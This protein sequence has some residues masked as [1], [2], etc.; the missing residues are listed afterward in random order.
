LL[1]AAAVE[2]VSVE[3]DASRGA[4]LDDPQMAILGALMLFGRLAVRRIVELIRLREGGARGQMLDRP[5]NDG[6]EAAGVDAAGWPRDRQAGYRR[7]DWW[8]AGILDRIDA[9]SRDWID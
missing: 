2:G 9:G 5:D 3:F 8:P 6:R 4:S 7:W 1:P